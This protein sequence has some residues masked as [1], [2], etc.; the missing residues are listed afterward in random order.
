MATGVTF[1]IR[2]N[3]DDGYQKPRLI[4]KEG[5]YRWWST[6][7]EQML[8]EKKLWGHVQGTVPVRG[9]ILVLGAGA[10]LVV[11]AL[12]AIGATMGVATDP[13][14]PTVAAN[15][16]VTQALVDASRVAYDQHAR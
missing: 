15:A 16:D 6:V 13:E 5:N 14:A 8:R 12:P 2:A 10:T 3:G 11:P 9:P 1:G 7:I 4:L